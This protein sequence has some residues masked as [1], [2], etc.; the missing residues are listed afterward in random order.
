MKIA[1]MQPY[2]FPYLGYFQLISSA[3]KFIVLDDVN[4]INR[5][6]INRNRLLVNSLP[7]RF[8]I[9]LKDASQ[10]KLIKDIEI[11]A[12]EKWTKKFLNTIAYNYKKAPYYDEVYLI[13]EETVCTQTKLLVDWLFKSLDLIIGYLEIETIYVRASTE[14]G[15]KRLKGKNRII[16]IC[17]KEKA[18]QYINPIGGLNL[19]DSKTFLDNG[20]KLY[21]LKSKETPYRQFSKQFVPW[22][23]IIDVMMFNS[24]DTI[25]DLLKEYDLYD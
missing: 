11:A 7:Y 18:D 10:N 22:L 2:F 14:Y 6:W 17:L 24:K 21:F 5:G 9:P 1:I 8:T 16:D 20:V 23:S 4:F 15:N 12:D 3:D 13:I 19:Y 25:K